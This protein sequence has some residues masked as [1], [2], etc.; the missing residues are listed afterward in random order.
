M[1]DPHRLLVLV[2][3]ALSLSACGQTS[4]PAT[5]TTSSTT[6]DTPSLPFEKYTL[7]NGLEVILSEDHRLPLVAVN[8][9]Y[10]VGPANEAA[11]RTGFAHLF[12]HMMF[13]GSKHVPGDSHFKLLEARR[14]QR[15]STARPTS[16]ARTTSRRCPS[17]QLELGAVARVRSHG[18]SARH[19]R[20]GQARRTSRTSSATSGGRA[21]RTS[22]TASSKR[23]CSTQLFPEGPSVL[24]RR[25]RIARRHPGGEARRREERSS[26]STTRRTTRASRSS[27]TSTRRDAKALVEKYFGTLKRGPDVPKV[28]VADAADHGRAPRRRARTASSCRASTWR[29]SRR[30]IFKPGDA[31]ADIAASVLGGGQVEP[32]LQDA[33]LRQADRAGRVGRAAVARRSARSSGSRRPRGPG[34][35][36]RSSRRRSTR[37]STTLRADRS[38]RDGSRARAQRRSRRACSAASRSSADSAASPTR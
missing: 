28:T 22:R 5:T 14:R 33:R 35:R 13:Q 31:D 16:I 17:N 15:T 29:G 11:G 30:R 3:L 10:H 34:T 32:A 26:S 23:R 19:G 36:P 20:S 21:S 4:A 6:P 8:L 2:P 12:E 7:A 38:R 37:S 18:L 24:R 27:A 9:W 1:I 25:H